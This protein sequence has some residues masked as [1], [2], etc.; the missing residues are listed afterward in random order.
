MSLSARRQA[1]NGRNVIRLCVKA[2]GGVSDEKKWGIKRK[3][4][5]PVRS[6]ECD[7]KNGGERFYNAT[8]S[9]TARAVTASEAPPRFLAAPAI[10]VP[11]GRGAPLMFV[12][13][14]PGWFPP[15]TPVLPLGIPF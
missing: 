9:M 13:T 12:G 2:T 8:P 14:T 1:T 11:V 5:Y 7:G 6:D 10:W 3:P 15:T 4:R